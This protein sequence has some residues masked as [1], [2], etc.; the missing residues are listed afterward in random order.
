MLLSGLFFA[1]FLTSVLAQD[2]GPDRLY[3]FKQDETWGYMAENGEIVVEPKYEE[4]G[5]FRDGLGRVLLN[6]T[7]RFIDSSGTEILDTGLRAVGEYSEGRIAFKRQDENAWGYLDRNGDVAIEPAFSEA[8]PFSEGLAAVN[9]SFASSSSESWGYVD[10]DGNL[11]VEP[12]YHGARRFSEGLAPV[13]IGGFVSGQ[14]GYIDASGTMEIEPRFDEGLPFSEGLAAVDTLQGFD[15]SY[16]YINRN[17]ELVIDDQY[18]LAREFVHGRAPVAIVDEEN[19]AFIDQQGNPVSR[20]RWGF[21]EPY[22]G[23]LA[24]VSEDAGSPGFGHTGG[25]MSYYYHV[26][27]WQYIDVQ[28]QAVHPGEKDGRQARSDSGSHQDDPTAEAS[29]RNG[30]AASVLSPDALEALVPATLGG[31]SRTEVESDSR[32]LQSDRRYPEIWAT[33]EG[34]QSGEA[35]TSGALRTLDLYAAYGTVPQMLVRGELAEEERIQNIEAQ[36]QTIYLAGSAAE[37]PAFAALFPGRSALFFRARFNEDT[38]EPDRRNA[39][40]AMLDGLNIS[41]YAELEGSSG[42]TRG[43]TDGFQRYEARFPRF[44]MAIDY[45]TGWQPVDLFEFSGLAR[46]VAFSRNPME[47]VRLLEDQ[48]SFSLPDT[49]SGYVT[50]TF[51]GPGIDREEYAE[52]ALGGGAGLKIETTEETAESSLAIPIAGSQ[53]TTEI[54]AIAEDSGG[55]EVDYRLLLAEGIQGLIAVSVMSPQSGAPISTETVETML[56][57]LTL[58]ER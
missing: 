19:W 31:L 39:L 34:T 16:G 55:Q 33:Y 8:Y 30:D 12:Q 21:A 10:R 32:N 43:S 24:R 25:A 38:Q 20:E 3:P 29:N 23:P 4:A 53:E 56:S 45:P 51:L 50:V 44:T 54:V 22:R 52:Q 5:H 13:L 11:A 35:S 37:G 46:M 1:L 7:I 49:N 28:E 40:L 41:R 48:S 47:G 9:T 27:Q 17:G 57:S 58:T 14:W 15:N 36:G 26:P 2:N 42:E 6:G 18:L